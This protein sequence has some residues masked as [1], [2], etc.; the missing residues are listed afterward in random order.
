M[1]ALN[2]RLIS[3]HQQPPHQ[4]L[5]HH[6]QHQRHQWQPQMVADENRQNLKKRTVSH[7]KNSKILN[8]VINVRWNAAV[9]SFLSRF[10]NEAVAAQP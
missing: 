2:L 6:L 8:L 9:L 3:L 5:F 10:Y 1:T 7:T 4:V